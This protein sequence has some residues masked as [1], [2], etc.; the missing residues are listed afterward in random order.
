M[1][2]LSL[3]GLVL[4]LQNAQEPTPID[5][6]ARIYRVRQIASVTEIPQHA[7]VLKFWVSVPTENRHQEILDL[8]VVSAPGKWRIAH[9]SDRANRFLY[10]EVEKPPAGTI[11]VIVDYV[12]R[13][14]QV[15]VQVDPAR[16]G[17][18]S[19]DYRT[20]FSESLRIDS[21]HMTVTAAIRRMAEQACGSETN[22]YLKAQLILEHV[23][24]QV[25]HY[26]KDPSK[27]SCG[28]GDAT[29]CI[30]QGGGCCTDLHSLF[31]AMARALGIPARLQM[32][33]RLLDRNL[34]KENV[35]PG[36][37]CWP[38]YFIPGYGWIP[39]DIVEAD[40]ASGEGRRI[41]TSGLSAQRVWLNEGRDFALDPP[42]SAAR[43]NTMIIGHAEV[44]GV[45]V[46]VLPEGDK[47][48]QL[49]RRISFVEVGADSGTSLTTR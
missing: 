35:D 34:G 7:G 27:P 18:F 49:S 24:K 42:A 47:K 14:E 45:P 39:C 40:A 2:Y 19:A 43:V 1:P 13:R 44:D 29:L 31:I 26:S 28:V 8:R 15:L 4:S 46:R 41:W 30:E 48:A 36:Y 32:G 17:D 38:E 6:P 3:L 5:P 25:D 21:P 37:R 20:I 11:E 22:P 9:D 23:A 16:V 12:L 33:Y 10:V